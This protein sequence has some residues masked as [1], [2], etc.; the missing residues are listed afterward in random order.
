[1]NDQ[2]VKERF[3]SKKNDVYR[4]QEKGKDT[5]VKVFSDRGRFENEEAIGNILIG[6]S[7]LIPDR[8]WVDAQALTISYSYL[9]A[10]PVVDMIESRPLSQ[11][12]N[13]IRQICDWLAAFYTAVLQEL[14]TQYILGD[15][16]LRNFLYDEESRQVYGIDFEDC[17]PGRIE[18]DLARLYTFILYYDPAFTRRKKALAAYL[19]DIASHRMVL[20]EDFY[21]E[22]VKRET[23]ELITRRQLRY[24]V[25]K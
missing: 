7:L 20:D 16:H 4:S 14:G 9:N 25:N 1:M 12:K 5:V 10:S 6:T 8:L 19:W 2:L 11:V 3:L 18:T 22:E 17:C 13:I 23:T 21:R 24:Q 15:S